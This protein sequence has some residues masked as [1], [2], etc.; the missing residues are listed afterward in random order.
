MHVVQK[1]KGQHRQTKWPRTQGNLPE[2]RGDGRKRGNS[3][4]TPHSWRKRRNKKE[5]FS[6]CSTMD[7]VAEAVARPT[8]PRFNKLWFLLQ[9][10]MSLLRAAHL[11]A[12][13]PLM[14]SRDQDAD[15]ERKQ[16]PPWEPAVGA[17]KT[18]NVQ[19]LP[20]DNISNAA[21]HK[22]VQPPRKGSCVA[23]LR[24]RLCPS[25]LIHPWVSAFFFGKTK[26]WILGTSFCLRQLFKVEEWLTFQAWWVWSPCF[27]K[28]FMS[29]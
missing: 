22:R 21:F 7:N 15:L 25:A 14:D 1:D 19:S 17:A 4:G 11:G 6:Q 9:D 26:L 18:V 27:L 23:E 8:G 2:R 10:L 16:C 29:Y 5:F 20:R 3:R 13:E 24:P 12:W 28:P